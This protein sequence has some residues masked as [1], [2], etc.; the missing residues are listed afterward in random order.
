WRKPPQSPHPDLPLIKPLVILPSRALDHIVF[1]GVG[2]DH[3]PAGTAAP[4]RP[5][6]HLG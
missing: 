4:A 5:A 3:R 6:H 1:R 2:L